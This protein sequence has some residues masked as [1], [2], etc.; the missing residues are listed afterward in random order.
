M[1]NYGVALVS[2]GY[3]TVIHIFKDVADVPGLVPYSGHYSIMYLLNCRETW[4][5]KVAGQI[6][7]HFQA[8][9]MT[10]N[11]IRWQSGL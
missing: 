1:Y 5:T 3:S 9:P 8:H 6:S 10:S 2:N 11:I 7:R 4:H